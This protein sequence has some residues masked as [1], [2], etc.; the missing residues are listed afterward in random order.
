MIAFLKRLFGLSSALSPTTGRV[1]TISELMAHVGLC[2]APDE[3]YAEV[4]SG[5]LREYYDDYRRTLYGEAG[6][7]RASSDFDCDD[8][9][10]F[11]VAL[12]NLR[13][14]KA[15]FHDAKPA[16]SL[17]LA[18]YWY[19]PDGSATGHAVVLALTE[20]GPVFIE[21]QTGAEITLTESERDSHLLIKF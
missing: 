16:A 18:E 6:V 8:F 3:S 7:S 13:Y 14:F 9:A 17:A 19:R 1:L 5:W 4:S 21:P 11:F 2:I 20:R 12:A 10:V 15:K